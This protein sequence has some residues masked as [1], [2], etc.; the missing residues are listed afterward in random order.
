MPRRRRAVAICIAIP[1][2]VIRHAG[3]TTAFSFRRSAPTTAISGRADSADWGWQENKPLHPLRNPA[4][5]TTIAA[6]T[7]APVEAGVPHETRPARV[8]RGGGL[9]CC[10]RCARADE[11]SAKYH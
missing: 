11:V 5:E 7:G 9:G 2:L 3:L 4:F 8:C 1:A 6:T 10:G